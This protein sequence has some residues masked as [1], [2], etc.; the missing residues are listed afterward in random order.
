MLV[1]VAVAEPPTPVG[2]SR[3][4]DE[5]P[6][7]GNDNGESGRAE[8]TI[9]A[10]RPGDAAMPPAS[11]MRATAAILAAE[12]VADELGLAKHAFIILCFRRGGAEV[13]GY[14][15]VPP[16][17]RCWQGGPG[18]LDIGLRSK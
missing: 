5:P 10:A 1:P 17:R 4:R 14:G 6:R 18:D 8:D 9:P 2:P 15:P 12:E 7:P 16:P 11:T 3:V 13:M